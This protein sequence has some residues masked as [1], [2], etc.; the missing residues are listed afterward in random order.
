MN[1]WLRVQDFESSLNKDFKKEND[2]LI[3]MK[4]LKNIKYLVSWYASVRVALD[5]IF[6]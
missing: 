3:R 2:V 1:V 4:T 6:Q 5:S